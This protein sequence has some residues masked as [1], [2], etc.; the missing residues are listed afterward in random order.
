[1]KLGRFVDSVEPLLQ[2]VQPVLV[3]YLSRRRCRKT[4]R[5]GYRFKR[6]GRRKK[7]RTRRRRRRKRRRSNRVD[8]L[9]RTRQW[10]RGASGGQVE[11]TCGQLGD[12]GP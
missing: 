11:K 6:E 5:C 7:R 2:L 4:K 12:Y 10:R 3:L 9:Q 8:K 1:M